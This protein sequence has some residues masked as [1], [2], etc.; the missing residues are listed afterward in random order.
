MEYSTKILIADE[1]R[2]SRRT[3][4]EQLAKA[5]YCY[6]EEAANGEEALARIA[7]LIKEFAKNR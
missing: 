7:A 5:G 6:I 1:N 3:L 4:R 2:D